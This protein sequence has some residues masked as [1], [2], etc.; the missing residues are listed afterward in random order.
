MQMNRIEIAGFLAA[1]PDVRYLASGTKVANARLGESHRY[2]GADSQ[3][4]TQ[5]NWHSLTFYNSLADQAL[6]Y[7]KG[8]NLFIEGTMQQRKF[9]P[10]DGSERTV[11]EVIVQSCHVIGN[12]TPASA[13]TD[14]NVPAAP[15]NGELDHAEATDTWPI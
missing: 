10:K 8:T 5:T 6:T 15:S 3:P 13:A 1:R 2:R 11:H 4:V 9:T 7:D 14:N 12:S